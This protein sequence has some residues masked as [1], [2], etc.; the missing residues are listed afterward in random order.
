MRYGKPA[1]YARPHLGPALGHVPAAITSHFTDK[2]TA[3]Q[4]GSAANHTPHS[5][6]EADASEQVPFGHGAA[7]LS[8]ASISFLHTELRCPPDYSCILSSVLEESDGVSYSLGLETELSR[9]GDSDL[10]HEEVGRRSVLTQTEAHSELY[11][12][13]PSF[14]PR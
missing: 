6:G 13:R 1:L 5:Q 9:V 11:L 4:R 2:E 3:A 8:K 10:S 14:P 12:Q 7:G